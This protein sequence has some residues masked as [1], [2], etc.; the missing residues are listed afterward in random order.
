MTRHSCTDFD[1]QV[2]Q[3]IAERP[4]ATGF[5]IH[6]TLIQRWQKRHGL[7]PTMALVFGPSTG[8]M[9]VTLEKLE[10]LK[11]VE[12]EWGVA[13]PERGGHRPIHYR[14]IP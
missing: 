9:Y 6:Q 5:Q 10:Q 7:G 2:L 12:S 8:K 4:G 14:I 1:R 3:I 13:T 11:L